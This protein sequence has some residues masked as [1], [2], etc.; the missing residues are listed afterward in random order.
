MLQNPAFTTVRTASSAIELRQRYA[1][2]R[3][4]NPKYSTLPSAGSKDAA[5]DALKAWELANAG[6][7]TRQRDDG[8]FFGFTQVAQ[9]Y[10]GKHTRFIFVPAV[11][12][13][14]ED[15]A[16]GKGTPITDLMDMVVRSVLASREDLVKLKDESQKRYD[17]IMDPSRLTEMQDLAAD[18]TVTLKQFT[19]DACVLLSWEKGEEIAI[20]MPRTDVKL[21]EDGYP[22][23]VH[24][25]G[26]GLQRAFIL[27]LLQHLAVTQPLEPTAEQERHGEEGG[28]GTAARSPNLIL[29]IE[30]PELY[31]HP[32]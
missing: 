18:L 23:T 8:Q 11:R 28:T 16:E 32:N 15:A 4:S 7:C 29:G 21:V 6:E 26:H 30:E 10:L 9:G 2:L 1:N 19:P 13:A 31:Q 5:L 14:S 3:T 25:T 27:T 12:D 17:E 24:R 20:P 22:S